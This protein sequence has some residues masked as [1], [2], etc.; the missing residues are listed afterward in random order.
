MFLI[1]LFAGSVKVNVFLSVKQCSYL[2]ANVGPGLFWYHI[3]L[4]SRATLLKLCDS[5]HADPKHCYEGISE[6]KL[7]TAPMS[8]NA[9]SGD[10]KFRNIHQPMAI[11]TLKN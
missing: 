7:M 5:D 4:V 9:T 8:F 6:C 3:F 1:Y 2:S 11:F 10:N